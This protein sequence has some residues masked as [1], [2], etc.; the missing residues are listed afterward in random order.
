[1]AASLLEEAMSCD[2]KGRMIQALSLYER[3]AFVLMNKMKEGHGETKQQLQQIPKLIDRID[4]LTKR[5]EEKFRPE[6]CLKKQIVNNDDIG[7][8]YDHI[9]GPYLSSKIIEVI[10]EEPL[11]RHENHYRNLEEFL[12]MLINRCEKLKFVRIVTIHDVSA[13]STQE[14]RLN[15][16]KSDILRSGLR[17]DI[18]YT[19]NDV[20]SKIVFDNGHIFKLGLG[21][22]F[23]KNDINEYG[24]I[25]PRGLSDSKCL[26]TCYE[27]WKC[28]DF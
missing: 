19:M 15:K 21:L 23:H 11:L 6:K 3:N 24:L 12:I 28:A 2:H 26:S 22:N 17:M 16:L 1:M 20:I 5:I 13:N 14:S 7:I 4:I 9:F 25:I 27:V 18:K 8:G 10:V